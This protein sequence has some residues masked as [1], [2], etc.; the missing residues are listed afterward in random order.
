[1]FGRGFIPSGG[2]WMAPWGGLITG[3]TGGLPT[4]RDELGPETY[5][6]FAAGR[7]PAPGNVPP[8]TAR[9]PGAVPLAETNVCVRTSARPTGVIVRPLKFSPC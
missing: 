1:M 5:V 3:P 4:V 7:W 2:L 8:K 6:L 9:D